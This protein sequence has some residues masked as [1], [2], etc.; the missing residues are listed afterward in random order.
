MA[1]ADEQEL[2]QVHS[3]AQGLDPIGLEQTLVEWPSD[4]RG[5]KVLYTTPT[6]SNPTGQSCTELRKLE[7]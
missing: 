6:G 1:R 2:I 7:M 5:P 3:D 4:R